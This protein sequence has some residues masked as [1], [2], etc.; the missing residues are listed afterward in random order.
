M[1]ITHHSTAPTRTEIDNL[2]QHARACTVETLNAFDLAN[3]DDP[4]PDAMPKEHLPAAGSVAGLPAT[5]Q[6]WPDGPM[7]VWLAPMSKPRKVGGGTILRI[8][9]AFPIEGEVAAHFT[10]CRPAMRAIK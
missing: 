10:P 8:S 1:W 2:D 5:H 3:S 9:F 6:F 7:T 4:P